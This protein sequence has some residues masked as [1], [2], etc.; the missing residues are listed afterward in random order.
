MKRF[1]EQAG[2][3]DGVILLR[4]GLTYRYDEVPGLTEAE[5][6]TNK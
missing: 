1:I 6:Q 2:G 5:R 3:S 4:D